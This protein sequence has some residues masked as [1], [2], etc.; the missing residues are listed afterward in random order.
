MASDSGKSQTF[1]DFPL[2]L[3]QWALYRFPKPF[4][5]PVF[6]FLPSRGRA[7]LLATACLITP[8]LAQQPGAGIFDRELAKR[9]EGVEEAQELLSKGDQA[10]QDGKYSEAVEA[11]SGARELIPDAP[12]T[13]PLRDAATTR[14]AQASVEHARTLSKKGDVAQ[15]KVV[16]EKV[17]VKGVAPEDPA[18]IAMRDQL[19]DP[20]RTN[21]AVTAEHAKNVDEVRK[22]LY[23]AEGNYNLGKFDQAKANYESVL[24]IDETN[25]A[26]RRGM[27]RVAAAK[28]TYQRAAFDQTRAQMLSEV[29]G[30][31][32]PQ[33]PADPSAILDLNIG[34]VNETP[35]ATVSAKL[36]QIL[37]PAVNLEQV[38]LLEAID[39]LRVQASTNDTTELDPTRKGVNFTVNLGPDGNETG[40][41]IQA[42]RFDLRLRNLPISQVLKYIG[43][44]TGTQFSTDEFSVVVRPLGSTST[45]LVSRSYRVPPDFLSSAGDG[46]SN[47]AKAEDP[48]SE[49]PAE[50]GLLARRRGAKELLEASGVT[51]PDGASAVFNAAS[52]TLLVRNTMV[53]L[54]LIDQIVES[55]TKTEPVQVIVTVT[56]IKTEQRNL[57][58]LGFDWLLDDFS[59][60]GGNFLSGGTQGTGGNIND[61]NVPAGVTRK[62]LTAGNRSGNEAIQTDSIDGF[63]DTNTQGFA[64]GASRAPG[65]LTVNGLLNG[66]SY[67]AVMRGLDQK[68][69]I[70]LMTAPSTVTR[71]G[72]QASVRVIR[73]LI[74]PSEYEAPQLPNSVGIINDP[75][76]GGGGGGNPSPIFAVTPA[77][78]SAFEKRDVGVVLDVLPTVSQDKRYVDLQL[79]PSI[80]DFDGFVNFGSPISSA[81]ESPFPGVAP[82]TQ[83]LTA[84]AIL[85]PVF[86]VKR[87]NTNITI[88]DGATVVIGGLVQERIQKV[89]DQTPIL[90]DLPLVGRLFQSSATAPV[91]TSLV[92][93]V[94]VKLVDPTGKPINQR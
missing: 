21:A 48:F 6:R 42:K 70:D 20:I 88:A 23:T 61:I 63:I 12:A 19:D 59:L 3:R 27:E 93:F 8:V 33:V 87:A 85:L 31:W 30:A 36:N 83:E 80:T 22:L 54:D 89:D 67:Q 5:E 69:G 56:M 13:G 66:T 58:E 29:A 60:G 65:I 75:N 10:Y 37:I 47:D 78:P 57:K 73:E 18:A 62:P 2:T 43:E 71:S 50:G 28:S 40:K 74:Y 55:V 1:P 38:T 15:A 32:E 17:L 49:K 26:A 45:E 81:V 77:T 7:A 84:N 82:I 51:F 72:Q 53:N 16:I 76:N 4:M 64:R 24:R 25:S 14:F 44:A 94:N 11:Y 39:Y 35:A 79:N 92:F 41:S 86:S 52:N 68:K 91:R 90:G 9:Y 46:A 34:P